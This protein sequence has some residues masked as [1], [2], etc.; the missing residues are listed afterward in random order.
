MLLDRGDEAGPVDALTIDDWPRSGLPWI[1]F[2][3]KE[4]VTWGTLDPVAAFLLARGAA[5]DRPQAEAD[6]R[7]YYDQLD[8]DVTGNDRLDPRQIRDWVDARAPRRTDAAAAPDL[9]LDVTM[10]R[11]EGDYL[12]QTLSVFPLVDG[13][14][15]RWVDPA[16]YVVAHSTAPGDWTPEPAR[17]R[18]ELSIQTRTVKGTP[19]LPHRLERS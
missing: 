12:Q 1:A 3:L 14:R 9:L 16:G 4:L 17:F 8:E 13:K 6:A 2:W 11:A 19:Y 5:R 18:F 15:I 10:E 7:A